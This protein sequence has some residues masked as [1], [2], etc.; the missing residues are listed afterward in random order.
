LFQ[1]ISPKKFAQLIKSFYDKE[2]RRVMQNKFSVA[3][4]NG[5]QLTDHNKIMRRIMLGYLYRVVRMILIILTLSYFIGTLW[6]IF[7]W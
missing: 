3:E 1:L 7:C 6:F 4:E 5:E 2:V